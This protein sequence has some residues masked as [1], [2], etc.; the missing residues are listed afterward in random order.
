M[1]K[2]LKTVMLIIGDNGDDDDCN[3]NDY[4]YVI[5]FGDMMMIVIIAKQLSESKKE[6]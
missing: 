1:I 5:G 3:G 6:G 4:D 2:C